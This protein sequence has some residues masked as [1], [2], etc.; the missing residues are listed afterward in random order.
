MT[1]SQLCL[2]SLFLACGT[3]AQASIL[4]TATLTNATENPP[5]NPTLVG[6]APRPASFGSATFLINDAMTSMTFTATV[7]NID[8]TGSQTADTNDNLVAA[9]IHAAALVTPTTNAPVVWGFFGVRRWRN[10]QRQVG[11]ARRQ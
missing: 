10:H 9:H 11:C 4:L 1:R 5:T 2:A 6:G 8:F 7:F 3:A